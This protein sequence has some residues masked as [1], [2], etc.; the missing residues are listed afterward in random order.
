MRALHTQQKTSRRKARTQ[1]VVDHSAG[2]VDVGEFST[3][4][5]RR[6]TQPPAVASLF[7]DLKF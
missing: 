3:A 6:H 1:F 7:V 4:R 5:V 2:A